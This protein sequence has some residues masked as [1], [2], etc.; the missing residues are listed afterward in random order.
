MMS[1]NYSTKGHRF[2]LKLEKCLFEKI[3]CEWKLEKKTTKLKR[4]Q[5][6]DCMKE[7]FL[8]NICRSVIAQP[9]AMTQGPE[10]LPHR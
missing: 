1:E 5:T 4:K 10:T 6:S 2:A 3:N 8:G 7:T 9:F